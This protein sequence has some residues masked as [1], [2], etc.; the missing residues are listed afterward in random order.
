M[1]L[2]W[3]NTSKTCIRQVCY[4]PDCCMWRWWIL[5]NIKI[6]LCTKFLAFSTEWKTVRYRWWSVRQS[7]L[8]SWISSLLDGVPQ[9][10][11]TMSSGTAVGPGWGLDHLQ[12]SAPK[13]C[14][15]RWQVPPACQA[16]QGIPEL[17]P[18]QGHPRKG[19]QNLP[20][21]HF[22]YVQQPLSIV[23]TRWSSY[24]TLSK[25]AEFLVGMVL[26]DEKLCQ[27][28]LLK[29]RLTFLGLAFCRLQANSI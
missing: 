5:Y 27:S 9:A 16:T 15:H 24:Y 14:P 22:L 19:P 25:R 2:L 26:G 29:C 10:L 4:P 7:W 17:P 6:N 1:F 12:T 23:K 13:L 8:T 21:Q 28:A 18:R 11:L 20:P 3:I